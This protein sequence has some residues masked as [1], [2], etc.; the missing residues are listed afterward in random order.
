MASLLHYRPWQGEF[1]SPWWSIWPIARVSLGMFLSRRMFWGL[2]AC[3]LLLFLMF[4]F[5]AYLLAWAESQLGVAAQQFGRDPSRM[6]RGI[7]QALRILNGS[8]DTFQYFFA[9]QGGIIVVTLSLAGSLL[10]GDDFT[11]KS[12]AFYLAKPISR[13]HYI[14]GKCAAVAVIVQLMTTLPALVLYGQHAFDDW[15]YLTNV[16]YFYEND[17]GKGPAGIPLL[18]AVLGYGLLLSVFLSVLLV[19]TAM[20]MRRTMP[21]ILVWMSL[22]FFA[23]VLANIL[24]DGLKYDARWRLIDLWNNVTMLGQGML[25]YAHEDINPK[26]QPEFWEAAA[27]L[28]GVTTIC[29]MYLNHRTQGVEIVD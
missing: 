10:V 27:V 28:I 24:V 2:Y 12:H 7:R 18:L 3:G 23:R 26:P 17:T 9:Y 5:G 11:N 21:L 14:L 19:A 22:F 15:S 20:W 16:N 6:L 29:L 1:H 13:W 4:F 25:A 8:Q